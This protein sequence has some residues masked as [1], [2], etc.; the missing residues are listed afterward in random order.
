MARRTFHSG[1]PIPLSLSQH[2]HEN[3]CYRKTEVF[4]NRI[5][6]N[7]LNHGGGGCC[8]RLMGCRIYASECFVRVLR[9]AQLAISMRACVKGAPL[10]GFLA[11]TGSTG[12]CSV[13][14]KRPETFAWAQPKAI[15]P[16]LSVL[17]FH[18]CCSHE[19]RANVDLLTSDIGLRKTDVQSGIETMRL[20]SRRDER[21]R[22]RNEE[23]GRLV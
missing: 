1:I 8:W 9:V 5:N 13:A 7:E 23:T 22:G 2:N 15:I 20:P 19:R 16:L 4:I 3:V 17:V 6:R 21:W 18:S 10:C 14:R 11:L 12:F